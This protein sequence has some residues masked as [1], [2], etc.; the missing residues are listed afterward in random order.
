MLEGALERLVGLHQAAISIPPPSRV[1]R[2]SSAKGLQVQVRLESLRA[3]NIRRNVC[4]FPE[5][6][7][8]EF[9]SR[10]RVRWNAI[11][12]SNRT[13]TLAFLYVR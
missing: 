4:I 6:H 8:S 9:L 1:S 13:M 12:V 7:V 3:T 5:C 2:Y 10:S 11:L